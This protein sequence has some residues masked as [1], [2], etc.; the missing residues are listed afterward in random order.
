MQSTHNKNK[1]NK[2]ETNPSKSGEGTYIEVGTEKSPLPRRGR[3][4][5]T[6]AN[7]ET[8]C[9]SRHIT[10]MSYCEALILVPNKGLEQASLI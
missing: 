7:K 3:T 9:V 6:P 10:A 1:Q 2:N 8:F 4:T 5:A